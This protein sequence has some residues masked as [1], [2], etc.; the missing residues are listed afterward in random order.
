MAFWNKIFQRG[1]SRA[2][3]IPTGRK[4]ATGINSHGILS[5]YRSRIADILAELRRI[6]DEANAIDFLRKKVPDVSMALWNF[7]RLSN[8][9]HKMEF[10]DINNRQVML[11]DIEEEWREFAARVNEISNAGLD[12]LINILHTSAYLLGNQMIEVEVSEDRTEIVDVH[13][14][15]PRTIEWELEE[16]DGK[17]VWIPYQRQALK[18]RVSLENANIFSV[19][20]DPDINDP[21]GNLLLA[22]ALQ[23]TDFQLQTLQ[24]LQAV[25]HRQGWPR[26]DISIDREAV[27][28]HMP[29]DYK[30]NS[31]K[32]IE[33]Y[34]YIFSQIEESFRNLKPDADYMHFDD[35]QVNMTQGANANR[36]LDVRAVTETVDVQMLNALKQLGTLVNR[37]TGK[38]ETYSTVEFSITIRGI[39]SIQQG[40]KR[41]IEEVA[42]LWLRVKGI[43]AIPVFTH[44]DIDYASELQRMD[45]KLKQ[46]EFWAINMLLKLCSPDQAAQEIIGAEKAYSQDYPED[47]IRVSFSA[48]DGINANQHKRKDSE[49]ENTNEKVSYL[50][51]AGK[52]N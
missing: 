29:A 3:P 16:R 31:K 37:H 43:Q 2:D 11:K 8:Q 40:S 46:Q 33:W 41:L 24:D 47:Q 52:P 17:K 13:V 32:Q 7:V 22:P 15:D 28:K 10:F 45:I 18:G 48:G 44:N 51:K 30:V 27:A 21:R 9:G 49:R 26:N 50:W 42:R 23:P 34:N 1:R 4:S 20:T 14:I 25:L 36:S 19:P 12:G 5:P 6:P 39:K 38:T 35:V